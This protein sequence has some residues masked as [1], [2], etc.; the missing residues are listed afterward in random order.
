MGSGPTIRSPRE[1]LF[2]RLL[3]YLNGSEQA[4]ILHVAPVCNTR[5][6]VQRVRIAAAQD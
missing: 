2:C 4:V 6:E 1:E 5:R 3:C